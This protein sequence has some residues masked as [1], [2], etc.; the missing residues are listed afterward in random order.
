[1]SSEPPWS[2][3]PLQS[4]FRRQRNRPMGCPLPVR[5]WRSLNARPF[6]YSATARAHRSDSVGDPLLG[7]SPPSWYYPPS[8][9]ATIPRGHLSWGSSPLQRTRRRGS[10]SCQQSVRLSGFRRNSAGWSHPASY[11]A[12][13]RLSQPLSGFILPFTHLPFSGSWHSWGFALQGLM[14]LTK[15]RR[16]IDVGLP[17]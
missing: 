12:A 10:T 11:G 1:V 15:P 2:Y 4:L 14:P 8:S 3:C 7:F 6:R 5:P 13:L 16:L 9:P 17:P